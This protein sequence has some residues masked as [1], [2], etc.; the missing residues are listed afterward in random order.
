MSELQ[1]TKLDFTG[2]SIS[3][4]LDVRIYESV[5]SVIWQNKLTNAFTWMLYRVNSVASLFV[6]IFSLPLAAFD[7]ITA[8]SKYIGKYH[9]NKWWENLGMLIIFTLAI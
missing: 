8:R 6:S 3:V 1:S 7:W 2:Q 4:G 5:Q 9:K